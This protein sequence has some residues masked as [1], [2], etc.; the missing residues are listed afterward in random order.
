MSSE[1]FGVTCLG[2]GVQFWKDFIKIYQNSHA[3]WDT[4]SMA[5]KKPYLK[6][7][8]Y[9]KLRDKLREIDPNVQM[10]Y[11]KRRINGLRSCYRRELRRIED[12][13]R[14]GDILYRPTLFYFKE[15]QFLDDVL[16][17][18]PER[19]APEGKLGRPGR[20][21]KVNKRLSKKIVRKDSSTSS[22]SESES[23]GESSSTTSASSSATTASQQPAQH[24][25]QQQ[26]QQ[27]QQKQ[28]Q[29]AVAPYSN[30]NT[31]GALPQSAGV[32]TTNGAA[33]QFVQTPTNTN[34]ASAPEPTLASMPTPTS[35]QLSMEAQTLGASWVALYHRLER[36]QQLY[37][38]K[39]IMEVLYQ[40][41]LG[42]LN[43]D[44]YKSLERDMSNNFLDDHRIMEAINEE[45]ATDFISKANSVDLY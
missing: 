36:D 1:L 30:G 2:G 21:P 24:Q 7:E 39:A 43:A 19:D 22:D 38:N 35:W 45:L 41:A 29:A 44:S 31:N 42:R 32:I 18:D 27:Q 20:K 4:R 17:F 25:H 8:A 33:T 14:K 23:S 34:I 16:D 12:S 28:Q 6:R 3:L 15:M 10:D 9:N 5:Y 26:Q 40:G 37:A 13:K 11:V